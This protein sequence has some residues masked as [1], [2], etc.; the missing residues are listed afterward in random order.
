MKDGPP[1]LIAIIL[2]SMCCGCGDSIRDKFEETSMQMVEES[3]ALGN[4]ISSYYADHS[5]WPK[6]V[7]D[8]TAF[9]EGKNL[10]FHKNQYSSMTFTT[11]GNG[12]LDLKYTT[13][14]GGG[15]SKY[16]SKPFEK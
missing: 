1:V 13:T 2:G 11:D 12:A 10:S 15:G 9:A 7:D 14:D 16:M 3:D 6:T 4:V 5:A 8:L